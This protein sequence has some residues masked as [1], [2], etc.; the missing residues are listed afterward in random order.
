MTQEVSKKRNRSVEALDLCSRIKIDKKV[1]KFGKYFTLLVN[2]GIKHH[3]SIFAF[4]K[5]T[6][7]NVT[8]YLV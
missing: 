8:T 1:T 4:K 6:V 2:E 3:F 7:T 5:G